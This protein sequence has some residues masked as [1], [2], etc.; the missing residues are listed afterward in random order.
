MFPYNLIIF[1]SKTKLG[2]DDYFF[3]HVTYLV[4][5]HFDIESIK[6][7]TYFFLKCYT[8]TFVF[9]YLNYSDFDIIFIHK[10]SLI[11]YLLII[12][13]ILN[14]LSGNDDKSKSIVLQDWYYIPFTTFDKQVLQ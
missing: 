5:Y 8:F 3:F 10:Y 9:W 4:C 6:L 7:K 12:H 1:K 11:F 14:T 13:G 2:E